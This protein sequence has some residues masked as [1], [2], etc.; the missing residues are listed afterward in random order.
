MIK[1]VFLIYVSYK[2]VYEIVLD[3]LNLSLDFVLRKY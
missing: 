3:V 1:Y 2:I